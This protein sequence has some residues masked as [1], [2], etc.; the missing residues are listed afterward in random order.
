MPDDYGSW[1]RLKKRLDSSGECLF[2]SAQKSK[3]IKKPSS[4]IKSTPLTMGIVV[5]KAMF[6]L[7]LNEFTSPGMGNMAPSVVV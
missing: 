3:I 2:V 7:D 4:V 5:S 6:V 1:Q